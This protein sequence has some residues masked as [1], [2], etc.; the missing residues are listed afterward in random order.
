M[1][2][3]SSKDLLAETLHEMMCHT[4]FEEISVTDI[5]QSCGVSRTTFY[6][7]F[8][9]KT[10]LLFYLFDSKIALTNFYCFYAPSYERERDFFRY[11]QQDSAFFLHAI[12]VPEL[13][14]KWQA[15]AQ[16]SLLMEYQDCFHSSED[17]YFFSAAMSAAFVHINTTYLS[18]PRGQSPEELS[19]FF[20]KMIQGSLQSFNACIP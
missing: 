16:K 10:D 14:K 8:Y 19:E 12:S 3:L 7:H 13:L 2:K 4:S 1:K 11:L 6:R 5:L 18:N 17:A 20:R 15:A 9:S